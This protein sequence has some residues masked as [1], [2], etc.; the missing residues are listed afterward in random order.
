MA[1]KTR[2]MK[3]TEAQMTFMR[4]IAGEKGVYVPRYP[5]SRTGL[6]LAKKGLVQFHWGANRW[7]L[8]YEGLQ[9]LGIIGEEAASEGGVA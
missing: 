4:G 5:T 7:G 6:A 1:V 8:T 3:V 9:F 2:R